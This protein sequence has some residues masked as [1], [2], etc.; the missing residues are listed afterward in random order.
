MLIKNVR[1]P[2]DGETMKNY[3]D[4]DF[5]TNEAEI[6]LLNRALLP[7]CFAIIVRRFCKQ[8]KKTV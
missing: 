6:I 4:Y 5:E 3:I 7:H 2:Y 8:S 1:A